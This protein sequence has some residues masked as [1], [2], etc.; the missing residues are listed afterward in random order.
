[1]A[2]ALTAGCGSSSRDSPAAAT[3]APAVDGSGAGVDAMTDRLQDLAREKEAARR[4][5]DT[6]RAERLEQT[7][8]A[9]EREQ[10]E[11]VE[12]EFAPTAFD[13]AVDT[14]PLREPPLYVRQ[15]VL[16][17]GS[18]ELVVRVKPRRFL[19]ET[20]AEQRVAAVRAYFTAAERIMRE[21]GIGDFTLTV[22]AVRET[23][24]VRPLA[25]ASA[26]GVRLTG[27]GRD[28]R[29]C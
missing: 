26:R 17:D 3:P 13:S 1:M 16:E 6:N 15:F 27:R 29:S 12:A 24:E 21:S 23:A 5:G 9:L 19:C 10:D 7:M 8:R 11:A 20:S 14:L 22:D 28:T 2:A 18:H 25:E 4:A